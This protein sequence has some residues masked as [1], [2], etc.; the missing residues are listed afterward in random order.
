MCVFK[1]SFTYFCIYLVLNG[2]IGEVSSNSLPLL[3]WLPVHC[4]RDGRNAMWEGGDEICIWGG[5]G[6]DCT[7]V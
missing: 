6:A 5:G 4:V 2:V 7:E 1:S 3:L